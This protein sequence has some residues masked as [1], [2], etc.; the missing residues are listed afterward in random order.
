MG[1]KRSVLLLSQYLFYSHPT[2]TA[3]PTRW[4]GC[5]WWKIGLCAGARARGPERASRLRPKD[6]RSPEERLPIL[7]PLEQRFRI[8]RL[9]HQQQHPVVGSSGSGVPNMTLET[10]QH[11][12]LAQMQRTAQ[13]QQQN[14]QHQQQRGLTSLA[15]TLDKNI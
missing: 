15:R 13:L 10:S 3:H 9:R 14:A 6:C 12:Q 4:L 7:F 8:A 5:C 11:Y 2:R 1:M